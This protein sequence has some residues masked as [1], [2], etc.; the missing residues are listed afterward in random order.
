MN[1]HIKAMKIFPINEQILGIRNV[2]DQTLIDLAQKTE[3]KEII[4]YI[5]SYL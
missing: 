4:D 2:N 1:E 3:N 5:Q